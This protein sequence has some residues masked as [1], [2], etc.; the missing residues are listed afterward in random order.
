VAILQGRGEGR[1]FSEKYQGDAGLIV[2]EFVIEL[3]YDVEGVP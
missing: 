1:M 2:G 3:A